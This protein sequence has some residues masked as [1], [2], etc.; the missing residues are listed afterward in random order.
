MST[1]LE[2]ASADCMTMA[3]RPMLDAIRFWSTG[4]TDP[5]PAK[6]TEPPRGEDT[7]AKALGSAMAESTTATAPALHF[8]G[9]SSGSQPSPVTSNQSP[10]AGFTSF[11]PPPPRP[12]PAGLSAAALDGFY[13]ALA[14]TGQSGTPAQVVQADPSTIPFGPAYTPDGKP[15]AGAGTWLFQIGGGVDNPLGQWVEVG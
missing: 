15:I 2:P 10:Y 1:Q 11:T 12:S 5:A 6:S 13:A 14:E 9:R 7:F 3:D 8:D 4:I